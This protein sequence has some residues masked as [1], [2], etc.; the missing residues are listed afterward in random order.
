MHITKFLLVCCATV[1]FS[2]QAIAVPKGKNGE[3]CNVSSDTNVSHKIGDKNYKCDKC[4]YTQC[5]TSGAQISNCAEVTH[6]SNCEEQA[7]RVVPGIPLGLNGGMKS[8]SKLTPSS[9]KKPKLPKVE[10]PATKS[11]N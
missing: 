4:V 9:K 1:L 8:D 10:A 2:Q 11:L 5:T 7:L 3:T 6:W